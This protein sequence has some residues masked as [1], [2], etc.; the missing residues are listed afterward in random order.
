MHKETSSQDS[1]KSESEKK[2]SDKLGINEKTDSTTLTD[3][4][5]ND[6]NEDP[7]SELDSALTKNRGKK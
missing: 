6:G 3:L 7:G 1:E 5:S 4:T 2:L